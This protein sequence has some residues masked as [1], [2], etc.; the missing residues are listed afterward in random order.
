MKPISA[1]PSPAKHAGAD[2]K[3]IPHSVQ[4]KKTTGAGS[5]PKK[6]R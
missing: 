4:K 1:K 5:S 3:G 2:K 6:S